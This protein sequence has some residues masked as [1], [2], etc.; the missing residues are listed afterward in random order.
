M[1][2]PDLVLVLILIFYFKFF[3][4][5]SLALNI[6]QNETLMVSTLTL[7]STLNPNNTAIANTT[8]LVN[9]DRVHIY[10]N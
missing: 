3:E 2:N 7:I 6:T 4:D 5:W 1:A 10:L 9:I 8:L